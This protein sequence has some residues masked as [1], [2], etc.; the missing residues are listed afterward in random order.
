[1]LRKKNSIQHR[2]LACLADRSGATAIEY[3]LI[4][5]IIS[6]ALILGLES[7]RDNLQAVFQLIITTLTN[8]MP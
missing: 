3:G 2:L 6:G 5:G 7:V 8:A 1:M 4:I